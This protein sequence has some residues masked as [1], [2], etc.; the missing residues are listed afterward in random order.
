[1]IIVGSE[2]L[3]RRDGEVFEANPV[4]ELFSTSN[5]LYWG[6]TEVDWSLDLDAGS[7]DGLLTLETDN[8]SARYRDLAFTLV[9]EP[10]EEAD[11]GGTDAAAP[12]REATRAKPTQAI[13]TRAPTQA[14]PTRA[15]PTPERLTRQRATPAHPRTPGRATTQAQP[16]PVTTTAAAAVA[17][18]PSQQARAQGCGCSPSW[19]RS[20]DGGGASSAPRAARTIERPE[21]R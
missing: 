17:A 9:V 14:A 11:A 12:T 8:P 1:M 2:L 10:G 15:R 4:I 13:P 3:L 21:G 6:L 18:V 7:Y 5:E 16:M 19:E 20:G